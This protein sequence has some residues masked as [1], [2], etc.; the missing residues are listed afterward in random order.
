[1]GG[2][3][4]ADFKPKLQEASKDDLVKILG[5]LPPGDLAKLEHAVGNAVLAEK[6]STS[7]KEE[8]PW[9]SLPVFAAMKKDS[10]PFLHQFFAKVADIAKAEVKK[11]L[12]DPARMSALA[13][14]PKAKEE[15]DEAIMKE[16]MGELL[17]L[18]EKSFHHHDRSKNGVL[19]VE[20]SS[21]FF[22]N[23]VSE[24]SSCMTAVTEWST[25]TMMD[26]QFKQMS[27][28]IQAMGGPEALKEAKK[29]ASAQAEQILKTHRKI[30]KEME[31]EYSDAKQERDAA[32]FKVID[33]NEDGKLQKT[34]VLDAF[35]IGSA[36]HKAMMKAL[37]FDEREMEA[38]LMGGAGEALSGIDMEKMEASG[39]ECSIM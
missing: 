23:L 6:E 34:E 8:S 2:G 15:Y 25:K 32:A 3:A 26:F 28:M 33:I 7:S 17:P 11:A 19:D 24:N 4:S 5:T 30:I 39:D 14:D 18:I 37:G 29:D 10:A 21:V 31:K 20:E 38:R 36:K 16:H 22:K 9:M 1:M 12:E 35:T 13:V 27:D